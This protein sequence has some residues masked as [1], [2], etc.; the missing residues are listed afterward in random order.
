VSCA[1][2]SLELPLAARFFEIT[3]EAP[4]QNDITFRAAFEGVGAHAGLRSFE[5]CR[6]PHAKE[7]ETSAFIIPSGGEFG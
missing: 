7:R 6:E 5:L 3:L 1:K 2:T 4:G